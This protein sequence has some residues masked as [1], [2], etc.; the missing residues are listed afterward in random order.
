MR[1]KK[2]HILPMLF[3][4]VNCEMLTKGRRNQFWRRFE[5]GDLQYLDT[6][7][8]VTDSVNRFWKITL[9]TYDLQ[10]EFKRYKKTCYMATFI[11]LCDKICKWSLFVYKKVGKF[12]I[13]TV[14]IVV[15]TPPQTTPPPISCQ[16]PLKSANYPS[17]PPL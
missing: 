14:C 2:C 7:H 3:G 17:P 16:V 13:T 1:L 5:P 12:G 10:M 4:E 6:F 8:A 11:F 9:R 15:S